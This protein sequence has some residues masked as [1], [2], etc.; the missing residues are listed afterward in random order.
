MH[1]HSSQSTRIPDTGAVRQLDDQRVNSSQSS[2]IR[3]IG[4]AREV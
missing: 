2:N 3:D 4:A 1:L